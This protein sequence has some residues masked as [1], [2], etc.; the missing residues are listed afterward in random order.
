MFSGSGVKQENAYQS[1]F[2]EQQGTCV[3]HDMWRFCPVSF[4][5]RLSQTKIIL[6]GKRYYF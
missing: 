3:N 2:V 4:E 5:V 6:L 1:S